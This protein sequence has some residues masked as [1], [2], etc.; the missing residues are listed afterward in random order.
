MRNYWLMRRREKNME[1]MRER[2]EAISS[3]G[4]FAPSTRGNVPA[5]TDVFKQEEE[6]T[7]LPEKV[8]WEKSTSPFDFGSQEPY[9][10]IKILTSSGHT[11]EMIDDDAEFEKA[12]VENLTT[13][14]WVPDPVKEKDIKAI[15]PPWNTESYSGVD[16]NYEPN[17]ASEEIKLVPQPYEADGKTY[18]PWVCPLTG[19][20]HYTTKA[21]GNTGA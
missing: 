8:E 15:F 21:P 10:G 16:L 19:H 11:L 20:V 14:E 3:S 18:Y 1:K 7:Q 13:K 17:K 5:I 12:V 9:R 6:K 4:W 2:I